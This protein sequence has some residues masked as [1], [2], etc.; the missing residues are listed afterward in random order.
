[1]HAFEERE[2]G[3]LRG[4]P[5]KELMDAERLQAALDR[6][7]QGARDGSNLLPPIISAVEAHATIGEVADAMRAVFG[8]FEETAAV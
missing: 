5:A 2:L 8:E 6:V 1:M 3:R 4:Q 7:T